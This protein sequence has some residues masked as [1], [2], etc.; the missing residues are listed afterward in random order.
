MKNFVSIFLVKKVEHLTLNYFL[1]VY[2]ITKGSNL[3]K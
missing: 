2:F 1:L 3:S